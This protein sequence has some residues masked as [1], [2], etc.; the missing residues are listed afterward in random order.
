MC[1]VLCGPANGRPSPGESVRDSASHTRDGCIGAATMTPQPPDMHKPPCSPRSASGDDLPQQA[2]ALAERLL[3]TARQEQTA[4][5]EEQA[6]RLAR[7]M[8]DPAGKELTI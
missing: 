2:V 3:R 7:M 1:R 4:A 5:E 8:A 6:A